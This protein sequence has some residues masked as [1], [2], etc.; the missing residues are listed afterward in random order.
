MEICKV[1]CH[2]SLEEGTMI[3]RDNIED[4][5]FYNIETSPYDSS[6]RYI[7]ISHSYFFDDNK[8]CVEEYT[9]LIKEIDEF[10]KCLGK[11]SDYIGK[12][13]SEAKQ[14]AEY[15]EDRE[16]YNRWVDSEL[17]A[18]KNGVCKICEF[19]DIDFHTTP[20]GYYYSHTNISSEVVDLSVRFDYIT[21]DGTNAKEVYELARK[22]N[23]VSEEYENVNDV[24]PFCM[25]FR[26]G[27]YLCP[28]EVEAETTLI[29]IGNRTYKIVSGRLTNKEVRKKVEEIVKGIL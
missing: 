1:L 4:F 29:F 3:T 14:Y 17:E 10:K 23:L 5:V 11:D 20:D 7:H 13:V 24:Q 26:K 9:G 8:G 28:I 22:Y 18:I 19:L 2:K 16:T 27:R 21:Y 12:I 6:K 25:L 15:T